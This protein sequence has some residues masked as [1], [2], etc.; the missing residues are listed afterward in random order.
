MNR[1]VCINEMDL[2][3]LVVLEFEDRIARGVTYKRARVSTNNR[4]EADVCTLDIDTRAVLV[5]VSSQLAL[6]DTVQVAKIIFKN[7]CSIWQL[8]AWWVCKYRRNTQGME[9]FRRCQNRLGYRSHSH[10]HVWLSFQDDVCADSGVI[11]SFDP[12]K[13]LIALSWLS[14]MVS[15]KGRLQIRNRL[16]FGPLRTGRFLMFTTW[17]LER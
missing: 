16:T 3:T 9:N 11:R 4:C 12:S 13:W 2:N 14:K 7:L 5:S 17:S 1:I 15:N 10:I 6:M 8:H